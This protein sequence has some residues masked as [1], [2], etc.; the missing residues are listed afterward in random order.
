MKVAN[1]MSRKVDYVT[2]ETK[3][4]D[5]SKLIFSHHINGVPVIKGK[6]VIGFITERD[7]LQQFFPSIREYMEDPVNEANFE[8][9]EKKIS[10]IFELSAKKIMSKHPVTVLPDI[11]LLEA[12]STMFTNKVGRLP[13]VNRSGHMVGIIAKRDIFKYLVGKRLR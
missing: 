9:M 1:A 4:K 10:R 2:P 11:P 5:F 6:K 8:K 12:L 3:V 13:V 7:I